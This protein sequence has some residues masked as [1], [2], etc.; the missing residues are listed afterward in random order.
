MKKLKALILLGSLT[1]A[2]TG[3]K[4]LPKN[5]D[6]EKVVEQVDTQVEAPEEE[7]EIDG[8]RPEIYSLK[9]YL[10]ES[11]YDDGI[12]GEPYM[13]GWYNSYSLS[14]ETAEEYPAFAKT[15]KE[16]MEAHDADIEAKHN[17]YLEESKAQRQNG[18]ELTYILKSDFYLRRSDE[19]VVSI[20]EQLSTYEGGAHG[21]TSY[22]SY[23]FDVQNG[24]E[25]KLDSIV[26]DENAFR[27][28][29]AMK[30]TDQYGEE[31][32]GVIENSLS[33]MS[34]NDYQWSFGP[35]GL[36]FYFSNDIASYSSGV[37]SATL[38]YDSSFLTNNYTLKSNEGYI[39]GVP[40]LIDDSNHIDPIL[41]ADGITFTP[42]YDPEGYDMG[43]IESIKISKD[44]KELS[45][46][47]L[48]FFDMD[49]YL[50]QLSDGKQYLYFIVTAE[51]DWHNSFLISL[52][53][54]M[55]IK[56]KNYYSIGSSN[57]AEAG[58]EVVPYDPADFALA[59]RFDLLSTYSGTRPYEVTS[60]GK[61]NPL[62]D[63]YYTQISPN[64]DLVS[65]MELTVPVVDEDG[66]ETGETAKLPSGTHYQ[67][68]RTNGEDIV[69]CT[70][71]DGRIIRFNVEINTDDGYIDDIEIDGVNAYDIFETLWYAG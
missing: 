56:A 62:D 19:K 14:K 1:L 40:I 53:G 51:S 33:E 26:T 54:D 61:L 6:D 18:E 37:L 22:A 67:I 64:M 55:E 46:P 5:I 12:Y 45:I 10:F 60:D 16:K 32:I 30:L 70:I 24:E 23:N 28:D 38:P 25:I 39:A 71:E 48:Y 15:F 29:L 20:L 59:S 34:L 21:F 66:K 50:I 68:I 8:L 63:Y 41:V 47:E 69:D 31:S 13:T 49:A 57:D 58:T 42:E 3:C 44:G 36:T 17:Q 27:K 2:F 35:N 7:E 43:V 9:E 65:K 52:D 4:G 11:C